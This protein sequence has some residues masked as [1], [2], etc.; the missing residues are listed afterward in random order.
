MPTVVSFRTARV[1]VVPA[2]M[3]LLYLICVTCFLATIS[4]GSDLSVGSCLPDG[5]DLDTIVEVKTRVEAGKAITEKIT[6]KDRLAVLKAKCH[7]GKLVDGTGKAIRFYRMQGCWGNPPADYLEILENQGRELA[8]LK[9]D[10]T[11]VEI[12]CNPEGILPF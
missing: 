3:T 7:K 12:T 10:F 1:A 4:C 9:R 2:V 11:V 8:E 5:I 6:V